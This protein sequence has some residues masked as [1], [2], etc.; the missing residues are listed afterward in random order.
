[1]L[2]YLSEVYFRGFWFNP[3]KLSFVKKASICEHFIL[4]NHRPLN[5][6]SLTFESFKCLRAL[7]LFQVNIGK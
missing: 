7:I 6:L 3:T 5:Y 4:V 2:Q 1:M